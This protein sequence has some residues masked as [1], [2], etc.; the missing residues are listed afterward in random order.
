[1]NKSRGFTI[2][3]LIVVIAIIAILAAIVLVNVTQYINKSK[4]ASIKAN[5]D[6]IMTNSAVYLA[7]QTKGNGDYADFMDKPEYTIPEEQITNQDGTVV[8]AECNG[9]LTT[10]CDDTDDQA[11]CISVVLTDASTYCK[12]SS[13][14]LGDETCAAGVCPQSE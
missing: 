13:G 9:V 8:T 6:T 2:I 14:A 3:E 5:I 12:D 7:D 4:D 10:A 11:F 1:M